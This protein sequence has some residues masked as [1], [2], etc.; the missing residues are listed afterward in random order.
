MMSDEMGSILTEEEAWLVRHQQKDGAREH[1][2]VDSTYL[3]E[4][5]ATLDK[6]Y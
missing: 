5:A 6:L 1:K 3:Y 2:L 4:T